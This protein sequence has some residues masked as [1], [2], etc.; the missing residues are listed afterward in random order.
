MKIQEKKPE[1][2]ILDLP[3]GFQMP[4]QGTQQIEPRPELFEYYSYPFKMHRHY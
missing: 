3:K 1:S 2:E 4:P